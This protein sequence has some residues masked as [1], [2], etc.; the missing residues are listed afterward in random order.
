M[1]DVMRATSLPVCSLSKNAI[2]MRLEVVEDAQAQ[3]AQELL[4]DPGDEQDLRRATSTR[5]ATATTR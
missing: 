2:D 1:S 3:V 4:A 5:A